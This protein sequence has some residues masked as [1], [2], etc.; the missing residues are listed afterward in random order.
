MKGLKAWFDTLGSLSYYAL[1]KLNLSISKAKGQCY[2]GASAMRS[3]RFGVTKQIRDMEERATYTHYHGH[4]LN[5]DCSDTIKTIKLMVD[6]LNTA[7]EIKKDSPRR[8]DIF[9]KLK[10]EVSPGAPIIRLLLPTTWTVPAESL[11]SILENFETPLSVWE[12]ALECVKDMKA[13]I[14]GISAHTR[15]LD[16]F[17][18]TMFGHL[19][20]SRSDNLSRTLQNTHQRFRGQNVT[21]KTFIVLESLRN[22]ANFTLFWSN[23]NLKRW[24]LNVMEPS[25]PRKRKRP[26]HYEVGNADT[27]FYETVECQYRQIITKQLT[28]LSAPYK[29]VSI[30]MNTKL[31]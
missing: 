20:L 7:R 18:S 12:E 26:A 30:K 28:Q 11:R 27:E 10:A 25:L 31:A 29:T 17:F 13:R 16:F 19:F 3:L 5:L 4:A 9:T 24:N 14:L 23:V 15:N 21:Q 8:D 1:L 6:Y 22:E 2:D